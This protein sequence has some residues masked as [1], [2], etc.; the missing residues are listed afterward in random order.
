[1][2]LPSAPRAATNR[3][4]PTVAPRPARST[5]PRTASTRSPP[6]P[7]RSSMLAGSGARLVECAG[8]RRG[9]GAADGGWSG[10]PEAHVGAAGAPVDHEPL[11]EPA[12]DPQ[13]V[14]A[15]AVVRRDGS[16][17]A[18][19]AHVHVDGAV[20]GAGDGVLE[21]PASPPGRRA[22]RRSR[23]PR[24]WRVRGPRALLG[25][26]R[27]RPPR[28]RPCGAAGCMLSAG[29]Q[30]SA[31]GAGTGRTTS[32]ATSSAGPASPST[33]SARPPPALRAPVRRPRRPAPAGRALSTTSSRR[34]T[35]PSV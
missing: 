28:R 29:R 9:L 24:R 26:G 3:A 27:R 32:S 20:V 13:T 12:D 11:D 4:S 2:S 17:A 14:S 10:Q 18:V 35:S 30:P 7:R 21:P 23:P 34:S 31:S 16:P 5:S 8:F 6:G 25:A 15:V 1:M 22:L 19:V 33:A